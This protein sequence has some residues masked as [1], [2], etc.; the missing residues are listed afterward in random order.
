MIDEAVGITRRR[1]IRCESRRG[2]SGASVK[3]VHYIVKKIMIMMNV[4]DVMNRSNHWYIAFRE[5]TLIGSDTNR[6]NSAHVD[7]GLVGDIEEVTVTRSTSRYS[8]A[9]RRA[10]RII[11]G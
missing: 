5:S 1:Q 10:T 4:P 9:T 2:I 6:D 7:D 8:E 3:R 11:N